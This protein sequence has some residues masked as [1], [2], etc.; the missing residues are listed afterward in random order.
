MK[1]KKLLKNLA[2]VLEKERP[3]NKFEPVLDLV[4]FG[5][6]L[7]QCV[8]TYSN[9]CASTFQRRNISCFFLRCLCLPIDFNTGFYQSA[10][11][12]Q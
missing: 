10:G 5:T 11:F 4:I 1:I 9:F 12:F 2:V 6:H 7:H 8:N 3:I